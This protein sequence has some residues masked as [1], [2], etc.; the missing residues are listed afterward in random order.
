MLVG[1]INRG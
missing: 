1:K